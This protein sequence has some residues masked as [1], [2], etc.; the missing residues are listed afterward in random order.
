M[1]ASVSPRACTAGEGF[2]AAEVRQ[3]GGAGT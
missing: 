1:A 3:R 2:A